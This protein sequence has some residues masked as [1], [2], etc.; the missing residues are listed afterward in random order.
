MTT[1]L[2]A[3][4]TED[5]TTLNGMVTNSTSK[6]ANVDLFFH[7]GAMRG[8][9][10]IP[11]FAKAFAEDPLT[12]LK[13]I[14]WCRDVRGGAGER[15]LFRDVVTYLALHSPEVLKKNIHLF[16]E[17][18][19]WDDILSLIGTPLESDALD[20]IGHELTMGDGL[21]AKWLPRKGPIANKIRKYLGVSPKV[22]RKTLVGLSQTVEQS[23]CTK[24]FGDIDYEKVPSLAMTRYTQA[25][26]RND[27]S[28]FS[29]FKNRLAEGTAKVNAGALYPYDITKSMVYGSDNKV[30][31][32]QWG[33]LPNYMEGNEKRVL[34]LVDVSGSM[35]CPVGGNANLTCMHVAISLGLYISERNEGYFKDAFITF[36]ANPKLQHLKGTLTERLI[37]LAGSDWGYNTDLEKVFQ[38]VLGQALKHDVSPEEMPTDILI[39][40]DMQFDEAD[41]SDS[42][43]LKMIKDKYVDAGYEVPNII[44]WNLNSYD[45][46]PASF[47]EDGTAL[48]SGFSPSIL[49]SVLAGENITP[50][51]IMMKTIGSSRY[52][53]ITI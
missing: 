27:E 36:S 50:V 3:L 10:P 51:S 22:Y 11:L 23:M 49:K 44:F 6:D 35:D 5:I 47:D 15:Q 18:G 13:I 34:P 42:T 52:D 26:H 9:D 30:Q 45:G 2:E 32:A 21:L 14:F 37:S 20:I 19:R 48:I 7:I 28:R 25:F 40:S 31:E 24:S 16:A 8:Q 4:Q 1:L 53:L 43:A 38:L 33:S 29:E 17:Y 39:L 46:V 41:D 12:A